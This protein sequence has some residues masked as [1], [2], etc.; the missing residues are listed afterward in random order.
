MKTI[1]FP[2]IMYPFPS[3][4]NQYAAAAHEQNIA[5]VQTFRLVNTDVAMAKFKKARF[6]WLAARA[7][8]NAAFEE[9]CIIANFNTWLFMLDDQCDEASLGKREEY[10][11]RM[12][13]SLLD[14]LKSNRVVSMEEGGILAASLSDIWVRMRQ[15]SRPPWRLRFIRSMEDYFE[16]C[17][18]E[19]VNRAMAQTPAVAEY[20][21][22]RPYT[23]ALFADVVAIEIIEK[24][25]LPDTVLQHPLVQRLVL[26][27]NNIVCW[28]NDLFSCDKESQQGDVHN[29][30]LVIQEEEKLGLQEAVDAAARMHDDEVRLFC[31]LEKRLPQ[32]DE[33][34]NAEL[35]RYVAVLK[36]WITG[37]YDWSFQDTGRY[38]VSVGIP[39]AE[40]ES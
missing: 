13:A 12:T 33:A 36:S 11:K 3:A 26:A 8:P 40:L 15:I 20:V 2:R 5:W 25:Y 29:L 16:S 35:L 14:V 23:G 39:E 19:A 31:R 4:I 37:N 32:Y 6:A 24:V 21:A 30:V 28:A 17:H 7:F 34:T 9:L 38:K 1:Q 18:W 10:L 27:C 22:M